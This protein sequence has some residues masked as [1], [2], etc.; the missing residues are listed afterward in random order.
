MA[1]RHFSMPA[2]P[3]VIGMIFG[4]KFLPQSVVPAIQKV[5]GSSTNGSK[6]SKEV[7]PGQSNER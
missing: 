1:L 6:S 4:G 7:K 5:T 3:L 2:V